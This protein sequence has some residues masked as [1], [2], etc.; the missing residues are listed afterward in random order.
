[1]WLSDGECVPNTI[2]DC[3]IQLSSTECIECK[4]N[5]QLLFGKCIEQSDLRCQQYDIENNRCIECNSN[6]KY[7]SDN[8]IEKSVQLEINKFWFYFTF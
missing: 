6:D 3:K 1:M 4:N 5:K 7:Y 2:S 8:V